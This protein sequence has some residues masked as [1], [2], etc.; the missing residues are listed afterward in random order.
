VFPIFCQQ[1]LGFTAQQTGLILMPGSFAT[2]CMMPFVG[3]LMKKKFPPQIMA[4]A[5][6][7]LFFISTWLLSKSNLQSGESDFLIPLIVRGLGLSLLFVPLTT[8]ALAPLPPRDIAQGA[9]L[10]NMVRQLG[11]SFGVALMTTYIASRV[12]FHR[13]DA[14]GHI[15]QFTNATQERLSILTS[16]FQSKGFSIDV[17]KQMAYKA[18]DGAVSRQA[19]LLSYMDAFFVV[20]VFFLVCVPLLILQRTPKNAPAGLEAAH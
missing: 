2:I 9:G 10:N 5:G 17:A 16:G 14:L 6:F 8:L 19:A 1:L 4:G 20:G 7:I 13:M 3:I 18:L 12:A 15:N 11:G